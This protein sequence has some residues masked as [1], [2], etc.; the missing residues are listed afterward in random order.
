MGNLELISGAFEIKNQAYFGL[1]RKPENTE[2]TSQ[3]QENM[4]V[5]FR[6]GRKVGAR[7]ILHY[8][9]IL[10]RCEE[11]KATSLTLI[12]TLLKLIGT[13]KPLK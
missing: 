10:I 1:E 8:N 7:I 5:G 3:A 4:E 11:I 12:A 2:E 9:C 6:V 13:L